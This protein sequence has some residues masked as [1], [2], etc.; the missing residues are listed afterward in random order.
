[1]MCERA[2]TVCRA[3]QGG[4]ERTPAGGLDGVRGGR[5]GVR[6]DTGAVLEGPA[7]VPEA[8]FAVQGNT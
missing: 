8:G 6:G 4:R 3:T 7:G 5:H 2:E 1:M